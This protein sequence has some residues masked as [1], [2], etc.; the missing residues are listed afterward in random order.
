MGAI[1]RLRDENGNI[2]D[3]PSLIGPAGPQGNTGNPGVYVLKAGETIE[4][5]PEWADVVVNPDEEPPALELVAT[6]ADGTTQTYNLYG[7]AVTE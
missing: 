3:V 7:E 6:F 5:A 4:D 1:L 2:Y